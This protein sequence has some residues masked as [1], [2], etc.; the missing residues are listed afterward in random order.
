MNMRHLFLCLSLL[1]APAQAQSFTP[2]AEQVSEPFELTYGFEV[3]GKKQSTIHAFHSLSLRHDIGNGFTFGQ[4]IYSAAT[5]D[6]GGLFIG[7]VELAKRWAIGRNT[8]EF[9]GF[10]GGGGGAAQVSG[11]GM[12]LRGA[13]SLYVPIAK[14]FTAYGGIGYVHVTGSAISTPSFNFGITRAIRLSLSGPNGFPATGGTSF[15]AIKPHLRAFIPLGS[16]NRSGARKL[17]TMYLPGA[18]LTFG[19]VGKAETFITASGAAA[20]DGE[21][22]AEWQLGRRWHAQIGP[23]RAFGEASAGFAGGG[24][25]DTGGGI[26]V[27]AG[28]GFAVPL[29]RAFELEFGAT[30]IAAVE[31]GFAAVS[32]FL[33]GSFAFGGTRGRAPSKPSRKWQISTGLTAQIPHTGYRKAGKS[34]AIMPVLIETNIDIFLTERLYF[35]GSAQT[36][37][38]GDAGGYAVGLM[39]AGYELPLSRN[40]YL[41]GELHVGAA[42]GGGVQTLGGLMAGGRLELDYALPSGVRISGGIGYLQTIKSGVGAKPITVQ[43]GLKLPF[44]THY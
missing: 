29:G 39:G 10:I 22:F 9:S 32:P 31:G 30:G 14:D 4:T 27:S 44:K 21:G 36:V 11:D 40:W 33:R 12:M 42:G 1:L 2:S 19:R 18:E 34:D 8:L 35:M 13:A 7:G 3:L 5:G 25:V 38:L 41:S 16:K 24:D 17:N 28:G 23:I 26:V 20:G 37:M 43:L 15:R 6:G